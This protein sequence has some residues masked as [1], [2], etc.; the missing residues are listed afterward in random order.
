[1]LA[2]GGRRKKIAA[3]FDQIPAPPKYCII[4]RKTNFSP[5][6]VSSNFHHWFVGWETR[7]EGGNQS[8]SSD[9][10]GEVGLGLQIQPGDLLHSLH[11]R[12]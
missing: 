7:L 11:S 3:L 4:D 12:G 9:R 10:G 8:W 6:S 2:E 1:M 5:G